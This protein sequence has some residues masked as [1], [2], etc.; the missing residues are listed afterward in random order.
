MLFSCGWWIHVSKQAMLFLFLSSILKFRRCLTLYAQI[1]SIHTFSDKLIINGNGW[2]VGGCIIM[3]ICLERKFF[4]DISI[5]KIWSAWH[6]FRSWLP[7]THQNHETN[8]AEPSHFFIEIR[9]N[10]IEFSIVKPE[11]SQAETLIIDENYTPG[12]CYFG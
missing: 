5:S 11:E 2:V 7:P 4:F 1:N 6:M 8:E 12:L 3:I 9:L 10:W